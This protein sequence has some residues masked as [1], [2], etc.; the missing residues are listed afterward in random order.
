MTYRVVLTI[1]AISGVTFG[2]GF[3]IAPEFLASVFGGTLEPFGATLVRQ[4]GGTLIG[5]ALLDFLVRD[6][7][8]RDVRRGIVVGNTVAFVLIAVLAAYAALT[9]IANPLVWGVFATHVFFA[10]GLLYAEFGPAGSRRDAG[11]S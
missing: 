10:G 1:V 4:F 5:V 8:E 9:G 2:L 7:R 3:L 6:A 11:S